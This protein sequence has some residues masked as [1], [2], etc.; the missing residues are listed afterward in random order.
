MCTVPTTGCF[1]NIKSNKPLNSKIKWDVFSGMMRLENPICNKLNTLLSSPTPQTHFFPHQHYKHTSFLTNT[2]TFTYQSNHPSA[3]VSYCI[4]ECFSV[5]QMIFKK[6]KW[7]VFPII[8]TMDKSRTTSKVVF[9]SVVNIKNK[10]HHMP[11]QMTDAS[12]AL[13]REKARTLVIWINSLPP[14]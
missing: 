9:K 13:H 2:T 11:C 10:H 12:I 8:W 7:N 5:G 6:K 3:K 4:L 1:E 14:S